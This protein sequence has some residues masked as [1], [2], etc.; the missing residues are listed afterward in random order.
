M[1]ATKVLIKSGF[2]R[3]RPLN[4][5]TCRLVR[6]PYQTE[7]G[8]WCITVNADGAA[9]YPN[10]DFRIRL[11]DKS[12]FEVLSGKNAEEKPKQKTDVAIRRHIENVF[13]FT[14]LLVQ[15]A[16]AGKVRSIIISGGAGVGKSY[17]VEHV[18]R[19]N[20]VCDALAWDETSTDEE[21]TRRTEIGKNG[22]RTFMPKYR[23]LKGATS[24]VILFATLHK[25]SEPGEVLVLDD[26]DSVFQDVDSLNILKAAL[27]TGAKRI[28]TYSKD[29][30][31]LKERGVPDRFEYFGSVIF[32]SNV[33]FEHHCE[34][35]PNSSLTPH[36][37]ALMSRCHYLDVGLHDPR[38]RLIQI[39]LVQEKAKFLRNHGCDD[40]A[41]QE[42]ISFMDT[43]SDKLR[44]VSLRSAISIAEKRSL[45][46]HK[47]Q[48][49]VKFMEFKKPHRV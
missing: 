18:L 20:A 34:S 2:Y 6:G 44:E 27:D 41:A 36:L 7:A 32:I 31:V 5:I 46:P 9:S 8:H 4:N 39:R 11:A 16:A 35:R 12:G 47:W 28:L 40:D 15:G 45:S 10:T 43:N 21:D 49:M 19:E 13:E 3:K 26:S 1:L 25:F 33:D 14:T 38:E 29:S 30:H 22:K 42:V 24:A 23:V 48:E 17:T 37:K